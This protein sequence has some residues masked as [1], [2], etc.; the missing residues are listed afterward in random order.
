M[1]LTKEGDLAR[2]HIETSNA[3]VLLRVGHQGLH[4]DAN[5]QYRFAV[6]VQHLI[7]QLITAEAADRFHT[8]TN[9]ADTR[10]HDPVGI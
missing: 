7:Q 5:G 9:T 4:A 10:E 8:V 3:A 6:H 2:Q 1:R